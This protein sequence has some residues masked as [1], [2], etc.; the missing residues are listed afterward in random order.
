MMN[1]GNKPTMSD[2]N[3]L[4][5]VAWKVGDT[6]HYALEGSIFIAGAAVQWLRDGLH[7]INSSSDVEKL[8][9]AASDNGGVFFVPA[10]TGL[11]APHWNQH[12]RGTIVGITRGTTAANIARA[13]LESIAFQTLEVVQAMKK[14][15]GVDIL[16]LRVD[17][18]AAV[19]DL[20]MQFQSDILRAKVIR[21]RITE[22]TALGSAYLAGLA[23]NFWKDMDELRDQW[24]VG[25]TFE[26]QKDARE[27][28]EL[29]RGW[30]RAVKAS[31]AWADSRD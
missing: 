28:D 5:T 9:S 21:P 3:L 13:T 1:I 23:V 8:A 6:T 26:P 7:I 4:T 19:D 2:S 18:G 10:F 14:D 24:Q 29:V 17:G 11:G 22:T 27:A 16:E 25:K 20:L 15:S 12:A 31:L 30:E